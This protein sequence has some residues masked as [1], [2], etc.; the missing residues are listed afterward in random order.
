MPFSCY[1]DDVRFELLFSSP[2]FYHLKLKKKEFICC[3]CFSFLI[4]RSNSE[5]ETIHSELPL[6]DLAVFITRFLL[7]SSPRVVIDLLLAR[8]SPPFGILHVKKIYRVT[9]SFTEL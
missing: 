1:F 3:R 2:T 4:E 9:N 7:I 6:N 8:K 5:T